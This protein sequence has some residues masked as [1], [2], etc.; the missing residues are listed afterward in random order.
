MQ[1]NDIRSALDGLTAGRVDV[2]AGS[3]SGFNIT[4]IGSQIALTPRL[5]D[6]APSVS[7]FA[8]KKSDTALRDAV[9][10]DLAKLIADGKYGKI[11]KQWG[12]TGK[13][14]NGLTIQQACTSPS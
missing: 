9:N 3:A 12:F 6:V 11:L 5:S 2:V 10:K 14:I 7:A 8:F 4:D 13:E 1:F